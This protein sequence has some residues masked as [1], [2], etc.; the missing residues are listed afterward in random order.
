MTWTLFLVISAASLAA[1]EGAAVAVALPAASTPAPANINTYLHLQVNN[2]T[3]AKPPVIQDR[4]M[5]M[6]FQADSQPRYVAAV[7]AHEGWKV[8]HL[9]FKNQNNVYFL[10]YDLAA[11]SPLTL[12]YRLV[13]DGLWQ[14]DPQN[15]D[16]Y[17]NEQGIVLSRVAVLKTDLPHAH[18]PEQLY[19]GEVEFRYH[20]KAG[21]QVAI[22]GNFNNWDPF[23]NFMHEE[24][25]GNYALGLA[26]PPGQLL[27]QFVM[28]TKTF[29]D[30]LNVHTGSDGNGG[31]F[32]MFTNVIK[33]KPLVHEATVA[34]SGGH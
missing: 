25:P 27:Y 15:T 34:A 7:F 26:L 14:A 18:A 29:P 32:S 22:V 16:R 8:K 17:R 3:K 23:S 28:G 1:S 33:H 24:T 20:G 10:V 30:P 21:Q 2:L 11:D 5:V 19:D 13:V 9:F 4:K 6:T 12:E 31:V